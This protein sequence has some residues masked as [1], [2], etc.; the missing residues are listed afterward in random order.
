[1]IS[2]PPSLNLRFT[3]KVKVGGQRELKNLFHFVNYDSRKGD[4]GEGA[5]LLNHHAGEENLLECAWIQCRGEE[6]KD[7]NSLGEQNE[8]QYAFK[9]PKWSS[10][11]E[12]MPKADV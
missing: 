9:T 7:Q 12:S 10:F 11:R 6:N 4:K 5:C 8:M 2:S 3:S 1:M